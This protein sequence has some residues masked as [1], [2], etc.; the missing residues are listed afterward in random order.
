MERAKEQEET[1]S[2]ASIDEV[3]AS[4]C[5]QDAEFIGYSGHKA[6][7]TLAVKKQVYY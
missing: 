4:W 7:L 6:G 2:Y 3:S 1:H 5:S